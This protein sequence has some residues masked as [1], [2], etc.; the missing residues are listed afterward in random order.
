MATFKKEGKLRLQSVARLIS[1]GRDK[2][3]DLKFNW[4]ELPVVDGLSVEYEYEEGHYVVIAEI[5]YN[6]HEEEC[7][8]KS[9]LDRVQEYITVDNYPQFI[10][11][12]KDGFRLIN[13]CH[14]ALKIFED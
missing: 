7:Y 1:L 5:E 8:F 6:T 12:I 3:G 11:L 4:E 2:N 10:D 13:A 14:R 9:V